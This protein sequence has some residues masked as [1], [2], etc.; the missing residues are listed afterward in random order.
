MK[1]NLRYDEFTHEHHF[2][3]FFINGK[4]CGKLCMSPEEAHILHS[5]I[6]KGADPILDEFVNTEIPNMQSRPIPF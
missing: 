3:T 1:I 4:N 2:I 5:I 6:K